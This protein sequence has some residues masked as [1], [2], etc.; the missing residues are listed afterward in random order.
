[1]RCSSALRSP[2]CSPRSSPSPPS[3]SGNNEPNMPSPR[4]SELPLAAGLLSPPWSG[5]SST[6]Q[7]WTSSAQPSSSSPSSYSPP[8]P[9]SPDWHLSQPKGSVAEALVDSRPV[10][11]G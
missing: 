10:H 11:F 8:P 6:P 4:K 9:H 7:A 2:A 3:A 5:S 1:M